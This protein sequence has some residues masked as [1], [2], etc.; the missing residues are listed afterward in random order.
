MNKI[1]SSIYRAGLGL[2]RRVMFLWVRTRIPED[3][4]SILEGLPPG[5]VIY[6]LERPGLSDAAVLDYELRQSGREPASEGI[7]AGQI[8]E[9]SALVHL[10]NRG[11][12]FLR[13]N[14]PPDLSS[15]RSRSIGAGHRT[16]RARR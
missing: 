1:W 3:Q 16:R 9:S 2:T 4:Q 14:R 6:V 10:R 8:H 7:E 5:P 11:R 12:T 15:L 13:R